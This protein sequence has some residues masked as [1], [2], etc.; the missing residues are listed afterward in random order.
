LV[1]IG[2]IIAL[3]DVVIVTDSLAIDGGS[4]R[5]ALG[6]ALA[7]AES[8]LRVTVFAAAG[9]PSAELA[10]C[11]NVRIVSTNQGEALASTNLIAGAL[12]GLWNR[13]ASSRM[14]ALLATL[15]PERT[16][17]HAHGWTKALSAS[18]LG[19]V[20]RAKF[21]L[22]VTLHEY[23]TACPT[24]CLY[25]HRDQ[26]VCTLK[27]MSAACVLKNC[28]S[29]SYAF[30]LYRVVR[31]ALQRKFAA[32][33][34]S[35][36]AYITVSNF[37]RRVIEKFL[38]AGSRFFA[39]DNPVDA[40]R[41]PRVEAESNASFVFL[42]RVSA[43]KGGALLA[44]AARKAGVSAVFVGDGP[45]RE[46]LARLN[47]DAEFTGWLDHAGVIA[48]LRGA[49]CIVVPS[50]WYETL[51]MVVLEAAAL[52]IPAIVPTGTAA[53]DLVD[54]GVSGLTFERGNAGDLASQLRRCADDELVEKLSRSAYAGY[55]SKP[56]TMHVHAD[57]LLAAYHAIL[58]SV[59]PVVLPART[60]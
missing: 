9:E 12:Q 59:L 23:F 39:V 53:F 1:R 60:A 37:S 45:E 25:L 40:E 56:P 54:P 58:G 7:L 24:G 43:E 51:G 27:P 4:A 29:R 6:S 57:R 19:S 16:V 17:V 55:W 38:P 47:P 15:D 33:P 11:K 2:A 30:K 26:K 48:K 14:D 32:I 49:R 13:S 31:Q 3:E 41:G 21:P 28:D 42:G 50:L 22:V 20:T 5:V 8:G 34:R 18:V 52:G 44:E 46:E 35:V 36:T 10:A